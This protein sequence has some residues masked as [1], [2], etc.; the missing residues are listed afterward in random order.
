MNAYTYTPLAPQHIRL[1]TLHAGEVNEQIEISIHQTPF[2]KRKCPRYEALS[3]CWGSENNPHTITIRPNVSSFKLARK[4]WMLAKKVSHL[5]PKPENRAE[6]TDATAHSKIATSETTAS[7]LK[8]SANLH[9]ALLRLRL[10]SETRVLWIDA[11]CINQTDNEEKSI[12]VRKMGSIYRKAQRVVVWL[13][14]ASGHSQR[15]VDALAHLGRQILWDSGEYGISSTPDCDPGCEEWWRGDTP[16]PYDV[17]TWSG[18]ADLLNR[19]WFTRVWIWQEIWLANQSTSVLLCGP[20]EISWASFK[21][22]VMCLA[23]KQENGSQPELSDTILGIYLGKVQKLVDVND[24]YLISSLLDEMRNHSFCYDPR[25]RLYAVLDL[26]LDGQHV[27]IEPDYN[28][29]VAQVYYDYCVEHVR[30][31]G[32]GNWSLDFLMPC[33]IDSWHEGPTWVPNWSKPLLAS[34]TLSYHSG[35]FRGSCELI[36][37]STLRVNAVQCGVVESCSSQAPVSLTITSF[38]P[39]IQNWLF[40][41]SDNVVLN[42]IITLLMDGL[43]DSRLGSFFPSLKDAREFLN[44]CVIASAATLLDEFSR[45]P[46]PNIFSLL[47]AYIAGR[48]LFQTTTGEWGLGA[49]SAHPGDL[50]YSIIG[51]R[52]LI[53][54]RRNDEQKFIAVGLCSLEGHADLEA[55]LGPLPPGYHVED[56]RN[57]WAYGMWFVNPDA[58]IKTRVDPRLGEGHPGWLS[59]ERDGDDHIVWENIE[60]GERTLLDPR[61]SDI[62]F[63]RGRGVNIE[64]IDIV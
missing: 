63:L 14:P 60:S 8:V 45:P 23:I 47:K 51:C 55:L 3:Y 4:A 54:L 28:K 20:A 37:G 42:R 27:N 64:S 35:S 44:I 29:A 38:L 5:R 40:G 24:E 13:G 39:V 30:R 19:P 16:L 25:D 18:I 1:L 52:Y 36:D 7:M 49:P 33:E 22:S 10:R 21:N 17:N 15:A 56:K 50:I 43:F 26:G 32:S 12:Q 48:R 58:S 46:F 34:Y 9:S 57:S 62:N 53:L 61:H 2:T 59:T 31:C 11:T 41:I 6:G